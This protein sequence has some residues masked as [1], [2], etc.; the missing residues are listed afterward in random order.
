MRSSMSVSNS[1]IHSFIHRLM[2]V[3]GPYLVHIK[4]G[5][6]LWK[7]QYKVELNTIIIEFNLS[8]IRLY[9]EFDA[10]MTRNSLEADSI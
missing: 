2:F 9:F 6:K 10:I 3:S 1:L 8:L 7:I 5:F 4:L